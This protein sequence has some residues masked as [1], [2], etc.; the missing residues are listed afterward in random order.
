M[1]RRTLD[2]AFSFGGLVFGLLLVLLGMVL[3]NQ[4][5][6]AKDY[7]KE[8]LSEQQMNDLKEQVC[9]FLSIHLLEF[10]CPIL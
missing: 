8:Q 4:A 6:F 3:T 5:N 9:L 10:P 7:V 2:I 1:K